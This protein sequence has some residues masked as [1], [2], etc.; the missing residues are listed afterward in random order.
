MHKETFVQ[1]LSPLLDADDR[2]YA[3]QWQGDRTCHQVISVRGTGV[4]S[5][6]S[7]VTELWVRMLGKY[8][9]FLKSLGGDDFSVLF[10]K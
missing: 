8:L 2:L 6:W 1:P 10:I 3:R 5:S 7:G 4:V 9:W